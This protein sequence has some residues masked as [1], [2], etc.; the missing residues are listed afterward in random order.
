M[1][2]AE[3]RR[4]EKQGKKVAKDPVY[5]IKASDAKEA[6]LKNPFVQEV[7]DQKVSERILELDKQ[8][9][10]DMDSMV[11]WAL[12]LKGWGAKR[13]KEF[14][15]LMFYWHRKLREH[16]EI[17]ECF[18][19]RLILKEKGIDVEAWFKEMF[20]DDGTYKQ[21]LEELLNDLH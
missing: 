3:R 13:C 12:H 4:L 14:Y 18:P 20:N 5:N 15:K 17:Q 10:L 7:I 1:N 19:E 16:Y 8:Y 11:L 6:L 9:A 21:T 2:R